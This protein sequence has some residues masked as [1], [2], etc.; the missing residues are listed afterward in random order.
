LLRNCRNVM[1]WGLVVLLSAGCGKPAP[2]P[3][4]AEPV[5]VARAKSKAPA[6]RKEYSGAPEGV[7]PSNATQVA[8]QQSEIIK[9][10]AL[11]GGPHGEPRLFETDEES[12][13]L[14]LGKA[15]RYMNAQ[16]R[17]YFGGASVAPK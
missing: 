11:R 1:G 6:E 2:P 4:V 9:A 10:E 14:A 12:A 5:V 13:A 15:P 3:V 8:T 17:Y 16:F 7:V